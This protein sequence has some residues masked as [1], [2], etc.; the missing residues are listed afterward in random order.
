MTLIDDNHLTDIVDRN[1][2]VIGKDTKENKFKKELISRNVVAF[3]KNSKNKYIILKRSSKKKILPNLFDVTC[4]HVLSGESPDEAIKREIKEELDIQCKVRL[5]K[6]R[7]N[8]RKVDDR[9]IRYFTSIYLGTSDSKIRL[10]KE[11]S[12]YT[13][14]TLSEL[15]GDIRKNPQSFSPFLIDE[16]KEIK[17]LLAKYE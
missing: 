10:N 15:L 5:L 9:K 17:G 14:K 2:L 1:D 8:E 4:G 12:S 16:L 3:I 7:Y 13:L 6:K 11:L